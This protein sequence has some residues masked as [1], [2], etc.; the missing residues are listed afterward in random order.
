MKIN[1]YFDEFFN[2][3][4]NRDLRIIGKGRD[5]KH[6]PKFE[7]TNEKH[8]KAKRIFIK[9]NIN[10]TFARFRNFY[11]SHTYFDDIID[12]QLANE[13][14]RIINHFFFDFD[15]EF[16]NNS[17]FKKIIKGD[18]YNKGI[19]D[20]KQLP[21]REYIDGMKEIHE[22][23][24]DM[25]VYENI[26]KDSW[27]ESK[28]VYEYFK[29]QGLT[30]YTCLSMSKGVH[31]RCFF[32]PI[33]VNNYNRIIHN[34]HDNLKEQFDLKTIDPKV[35][36]KDSNP[37]KSVE[38]LPYTYNE[39]SGLRVTPFSFE[40]DRLSDVIERSLKLS[41][42]KTLVNVDP[43]YLSDFVNDD[44]HNGILKLDSQINV[45]V[46]KERDAK[47]KLMQQRI[48]N[49]TINGRYT[50]ENG[51]FQDLRILVRFVCGEDN[52][53]SEHDRYDKWKCV[54]H[55]DKSPSAIVGV[56]KYTCLSSNCKI[57]K[58]NYFEFIKE[59]FHLKSDD[60]VKEKM[61]ELQDLYDEK[62]GKT[63]SLS[64]DDVE[65][66]LNEMEHEIDA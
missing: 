61:V 26:L 40:H 2:N 53:V 63:R 60:E 49:G 52:L 64:G 11:G 30:T 59:W 27:N 51:L 12:Y 65:K 31:L 54:F 34:L 55:D 41:D 62:V 3:N 8:A 18:E 7:T 25:I 66:I 14:A 47:E 32:K 19:E 45:L 33:H 6:A 39:K 17:K 9:N 29:E 13:D 16:A 57:G 1:D 28:K 4:Y 10:S 24:Q 44:F 56:K 5:V 38:R 46:A 36:G 23:I 48:A 42:K 22:Q 50:G 21:L 20:L 15:K 43:F 35:T 37:S 58:I